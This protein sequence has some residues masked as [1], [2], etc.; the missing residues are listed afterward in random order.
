MNNRWPVFLDTDIGDDIDDAL[1]L[2]LATRSPEIELLGVSTVFGETRLRAR[3]A[4]HLLRVYERPGIPVAAGCGEPLKRRHAPSG[5]PQAAL[6]DWHVDY[7]LSELDGPELLRR[8]AREQRGRLILLCLGPLTNLAIALRR[9]PELVRWLA[10]VILMGGTGGLPWPEWNV[11]SDALAAHLVLTSSLPITLIGWNVTSRCQMRAQDLKRLRSGNSERTHLLWQLLQI[12]QR[13][14]PRWHPALPYLH[15]PLT[16]TAL[17][18]PDLFTFARMP[19][20]VAL[21]GPLQG[22]MTP[23]LPGGALV[24][25]ATSVRADAARAWI[26]QRLCE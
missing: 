24:Q 25:A 10:R 4:A 5:V 7:A 1:A 21:S 12:W 15:D 16:V 22:L 9:E 8:V 11:R 13:H 20:H 26:M 6:L 14:R 17:C 2:A 19:V 3:L 23:R 18:A